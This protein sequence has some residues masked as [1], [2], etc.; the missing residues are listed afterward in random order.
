MGYTMREI[1]EQQKE[2]TIIRKQ[3]EISAQRYEMKQK[4]KAKVLQMRLKLR[5]VVQAISIKNR[6]DADNRHTKHCQTS[7]RH[8]K[9]DFS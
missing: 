2:C 9:H 5:D 3:R 4:C 7:A 6:F 1:Q 8:A